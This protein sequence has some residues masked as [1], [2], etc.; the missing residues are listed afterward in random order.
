MT[1]DST[2]VQGEDLIHFKNIFYVNTSLLS[3]S[4]NK[5]TIEISKTI[6]DTTGDK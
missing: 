1:L 2:G 5:K 3:S 6:I 4:S